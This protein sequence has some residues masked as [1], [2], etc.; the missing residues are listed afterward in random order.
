MHTGIGGSRQPWQ[1]SFSHSPLVHPKAQVRLTVAYWQAPAMQLP[2]ARKAVRSLAEVH[3]AAGGASQPPHVTPPRPHCEPFCWLGRRQVPF[4]VQQP[5]G[6]LVGSHTHAPL[7]HRCPKAHGA[8]LPHWHCPSAEQPSLWVP[9][10]LQTEF[11]RPQVSTPRVAQ[12]V[13]VQQ[14]VEHVCRQPAHAPSMHSS[15][16]G[17]CWQA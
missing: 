5:S 9:Q 11:D 12:V 3:W 10:A 14:P 8:L 6:Q 4:E 1:T 2:G 17:H 15:P 16:L 13:P 7:A